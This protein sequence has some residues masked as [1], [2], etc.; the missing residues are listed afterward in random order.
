MKL[1]HLNQRQLAARWDI[2]EATLEHWR[3]EAYRKATLSLVLN[4]PAFGGDVKPVITGNFVAKIESTCRF[5]C[6][7]CISAYEFRL[8]LFETSAWK[9]TSVLHDIV[10]CNGYRIQFDDPPAIF[11]LGWI[12]GIN[13]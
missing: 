10:I 8:F 13:S 5:G 1:I 6:A 4:R 12:F 7:R 9:K 11:T 3:G 2:S